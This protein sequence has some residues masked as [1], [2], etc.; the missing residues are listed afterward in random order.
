MHFSTVFFNLVSTHDPFPP[1][2]SADLYGR[3]MH[4]LVDHGVA[5]CLSVFKPR[6]YSLF[7]VQP[8]SPYRPPATG[9]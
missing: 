9:T 3:T 1:S 8:Y 4:D 6:T 7:V 2:G 5:V